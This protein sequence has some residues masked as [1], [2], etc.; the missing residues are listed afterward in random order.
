[1]IVVPAAEKLEGSDVFDT[2]M[3]G[4]WIAGTVA[5][6]LLD[7]GLPE[8]ALGGDGPRVGDAPAFDVGLGGGV[9]G[10]AGLD[11]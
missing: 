4:V 6:R 7:D 9:G 2:A 5:R 8:W 10:G 11:V 1:M 3:A